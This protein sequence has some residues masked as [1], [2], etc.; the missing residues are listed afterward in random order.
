M[1]N[2]RPVWTPLPALEI[3]ELINKVQKR[4][5]TTSIIIT[6]DLT[7]A[8]TT[9]DR[10]VMM[11]DGKFIREGSFEAVFDTEDER[12]KRFYDYNFIQ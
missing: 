12:V 7:C 3:N 10:I 8:K 5:N 9:G 2:L 1:M 6:H 11:M 4:F